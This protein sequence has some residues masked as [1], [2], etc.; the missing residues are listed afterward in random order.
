MSTGSLFERTRS[1]P[2]AQWPASRGRPPQ[3]R[4]VQQHPAT[5]VARCAIGSASTS[6][7]LPL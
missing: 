2:Q 4:S 6:P 1:Q 3:T 7:R 5:L